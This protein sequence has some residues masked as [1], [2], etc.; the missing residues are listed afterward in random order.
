MFGIV[1]RCLINWFLGKITICVFE[2]NDFFA[3][4]VKESKGFCSLLKE[5]T[6]S[7]GGLYQATKRKGLLLGVDISTQK[8][9]SPSEGTSTL[10]V[11][12]I[13]SLT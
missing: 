1:I 6:G 8:S 3:F 12:L 13:E 2:E 10:G 7:L 11:I 4:L 5:S 9:S